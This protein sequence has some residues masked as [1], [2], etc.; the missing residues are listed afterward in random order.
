MTLG[1]PGGVGP[2]LVAR[3]AAD[4]PAG[5]QPMVFGTARAWAAGAE[6]AGI[7]FASVEALLY[8]C[9][10]P[11]SV[12]AGRPSRAGGECAL[13]A[14]DAAVR[15]ARQGRI[16]GVVT[17]PISKL[18]FSLAGEKRPGHTELLAHLC[19]VP[20]ATMVF[21]AESLRVALFTTHIPLEEVCRRVEKHA[22]L[23]CI[24]RL[25]HALEQEFAE[26]GVPIGIASLNPHRGEEGLFG[27]TEIDEIAPAVAMAKARGI[28]AS[29][30]ERNEELLRR[31]PSGPPRG[32]VALYHDQ[33]LT[34]LKSHKDLPMV[35]VS[36]G[37]PIVRTSPD[38]G[39][40]FELVG[41]SEASA[42][43]LYL[44]TRWA[45]R[46]A[47]VRRTPALETKA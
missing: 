21:V 29:G 9:E 6:R 28:L 12:P 24:V 34:P 36:V 15:A 44:A 16:D 33:A 35:N 20:R 26:T 14:I 3:V 47:I 40:A 5:V 13:A 42:T 8:K 37:L 27:R 22:L 30:P 10:G 2:E 1:D 31:R 45:Q 7:P 39:T 11:S 43:G 17:A 38:H 19:A 41:T 32:V 23:D 4:P 46:L 18:S 25:H